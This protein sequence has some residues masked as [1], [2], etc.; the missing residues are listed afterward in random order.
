ML[1]NPYIRDD[2][3]GGGGVRGGAENKPRRQD[4]KKQM[5]NGNKPRHK[6]FSRCKALK[7]TAKKCHTVLLLTS[8]GLIFH[9]AKSNKTIVELNSY[10]YVNKVA[11]CNYWKYHQ[12]RLNDFLV[13]GFLNA[14]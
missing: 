10:R 1:A 7:N 6:A 11:V 8:M 13:L 2:G 14:G 12:P 3:F 9:R 5:K 4:K